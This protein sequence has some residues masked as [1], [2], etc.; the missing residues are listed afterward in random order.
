MGLTSEIYLTKKYVMKEEWLELIKTISNYNGI[1]RKWQIIITNDKNQIRYFV[2]TRCTLPATINNLNSFL[3]KATQE[4]TKPKATLTFLTGSKISN[5]IIDLINY[6]EIKNKGTLEYLEINF[7]KLYDDKIKVNISYYLNKNGIIKKYKMILGIPANIL[8]VDFEGNKRYFYKS[9]PK[10]LEI[11]KVLHL[12]GSDTNNSL[13]SIDTFP[14]LQGNFYLNQNNFSFDKHSI[15]FGSS[16]SGKSKLISLLINNISKSENLRQKY[17]VV[18]I[19]PHASLENDIGGLGKVIDFK[20][21]LDSVDLFINN[22]D[23]IISSTE[24]LLDLFK[25]LIADQYNSKLERVLRHSIHLLLTNETFNFCNLRKLLL[26]LEYRND[27]IRKLKYNLPVSVIDFFLADFNDLKTKAYGEAISPIISFIDEMEMIPVFN[28][29]NNTENLKNTIHNNFL[30]LFSL[31]RAKL[32]DKVT[33]TIAGLIMQQ[34]L[35]IMQKQEIDEHIIFMID[36]VAVVE[37]PILSRYLSE[38]RKYNLSLI[39]AGQYFNQISDE[40]KNS[41]FANVINYFIFRVS[42][43]DANIL[44]DNF[45]MKIP[46]DDSKEQ[47]I[48]LLTE[49]QTRECIVRID[50][51]GI[52][53]P[54]FKGITLDYTSIPR[55]K[56][57][58]LNDNNKLSKDKPNNFKT[59]FKINTNVSLKDILI[60]NSTNKKGM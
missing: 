55:I 44:V 49:L 22:T 59:N 37:N 40:L 25:S 31:D 3:L 48:K 7:L 30:T 8:S 53:L 54:A 10:Y 18:V 13:L 6:N 52:L 2:K 43:L 32:G 33:K 21:N 27:L 17:K 42:K 26:D 57:T 12:L 23:D 9:A 1:L 39:L 24:L 34:L 29:E 16:G 19:D 36:E 14:Y 35:T 41:I 60:S 47:K 58:N 50:S 38:A 45:N 51:N 46:L 20:N 56:T 4:I 11:N 5:N 15:I 28:E